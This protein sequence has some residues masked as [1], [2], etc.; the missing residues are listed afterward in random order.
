[1][2]RDA[3]LKA[4]QALAALEDESF[5]AVMGQLEGQSWQ[6]NVDEATA[7]AFLGQLTPREREAV[8]DHIDDSVGECDCCKQVG[9]LSPMVCS[10]GEDGDCCSWGCE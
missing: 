8:I 4:H 1:M 10:S 3:M 9:P 6:V 5:D 2:N 7:V